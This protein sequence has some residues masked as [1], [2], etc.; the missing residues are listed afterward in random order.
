MTIDIGDK[1]H[2]KKCSIIT[3][4]LIFCILCSVSLFVFSYRF[5]NVEITPKWLGLMICVGIAGLTGSMLGRTITLRTK[6]L[7]SLICCFLCVLG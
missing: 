6:P 7:I 4:V 3:G 5:V 1:K 2:V